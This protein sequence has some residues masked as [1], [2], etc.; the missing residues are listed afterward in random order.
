MEKKKILLICPRLGQG[1]FEKVCALTGQLLKPYFDV[2]I[3]VFDGTEILFDI[4]GT[5]LLDIHV[6]SKNGKIR[7]MFNVFLRIARLRRIKRSKKIDISYSFGPSAN[8]P[9]VLSTNKG[10]TTW[11]G[12]RS[13]MDLSGGAL[14]KIC[15]RKADKVICCAKEIE[16]ELG[17][18]F[19]IQTLATV[20]NPFDVEKIEKLSEVKAEFPW[21]EDSFVIASMGREDD[22]KGFWHLIK[23]F[24]LLHRRCENTRLMIIGEGNYEEYKKLAEDYGILNQIFFTGVKSNPY[25]YLKKADLYVLTSLNEGFPNALVEAM[26]LSIPVIATDCLTGPAEI[27]SGENQSRDTDEVIYGKYGIL[28]PRVSSEKNLDSSIIEEEEKTLAKVME[29]LLKDTTLRQS[30]QAKSRERAKDFSYSDYVSSI[31]NLV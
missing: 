31:L 19:Q 16:A 4:G 9:N 26:A 5:E 18:R 13:Y 29:E 20:Y 3:A 1:G 7:K 14:L 30:Y 23:S 10:T 21:P 28:I 12:I 25:G 27:L 11:I 15:C 6:P 8:L 22:V 17:K 24:S 2:Y